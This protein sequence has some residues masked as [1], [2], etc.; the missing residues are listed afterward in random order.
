MELFAQE[1][2]KTFCF[3]DIWEEETLGLK[4]AVAPPRR[5][6]DNYSLLSSDGGWGGIFREIWA[7]HLHRDEWHTGKSS[8]EGL[9]YSGRVALEARLLCP[10]HYRQN[11]RTQRAI[12]LNSASFSA[13][14]RGARK[15]QCQMVNL[16]PHT[17]RPLPNSLE[18]DALHSSKYFLS[19]LN[20]RL[21]NS[22]SIL[23]SLPKKCETW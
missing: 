2:L 3:E 18:T 1:L 9:S 13:G 23:C 8:Q 6:N 14:L 11:S 7:R 10:L 19:T 21:T 22:L 15:R 4:I 12:W 16:S 5:A 17:K 20:A